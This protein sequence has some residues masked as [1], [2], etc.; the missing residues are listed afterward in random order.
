MPP[1]DTIA[2]RRTSGY[3]AARTPADLPVLAPGALAVSDKPALILHLVLALTLASAEG[4]D[5]GH[6]AF[7]A[8]HVQHRECW[9]K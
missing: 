6:N 1:E 4:V 2:R 8:A 3:G 5:G 7:A 9:K